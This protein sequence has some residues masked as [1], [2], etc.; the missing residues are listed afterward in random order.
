MWHAIIIIGVGEIWVEARP[1]ICFAIVINHFWGCFYPMSL[2]LKLTL[3]HPAFY[4]HSSSHVFT[5]QHPRIQKRN[6][7]EDM[8]ESRWLLS[9]MSLLPPMKTKG[10]TPLNQTTLLFLSRDEL[11][12]LSRAQG[13]SWN[14]LLLSS[15]G[16]KLSGA[17]YAALT[18]TRCTIITTYNH[19][20][21]FGGQRKEGDKLLGKIMNILQK[22]LSVSALNS[23]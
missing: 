8:K 19:Q 23:F 3:H 13:C 1:W 17:K 22:Y 21:P 12:A 5:Q 9:S 11:R 4:P 2:Y 7:S 6:Q 15:S 20:G 16:K 14:V 10:R 18:A